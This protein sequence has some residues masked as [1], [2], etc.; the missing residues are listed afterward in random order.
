MPLTWSVASE[1]KVET[2]KYT[3]YVRVSRIQLGTTLGERVFLYFATV[4][5]QV[6]IPVI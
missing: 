3:V 5:E 1:L 6:Q 4:K 2:Q